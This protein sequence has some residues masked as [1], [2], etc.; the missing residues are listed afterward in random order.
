MYEEKHYIKN[1][2]NSHALVRNIPVYEVT[3]QSNGHG[4]FTADKTTGYMNDVIS[5][6]ATP[7]ADYSFDGYAIT[8]ATLTGNQ[9]AINGSDVT[10]QAIFTQAP[11]I[12]A[13]GK[14]FQFGFPWGGV[15]SDDYF[16]SN[17]ANVHELTDTYAVLK[18]K[19][20][21]QDLNPGTQYT[22]EL[23]AGIQIRNVNADAPFSWRLSG[24]HDTRSNKVLFAMHTN[25]KPSFSIATAYVETAQAGLVGNNTREYAVITKQAIATSE[26]QYKYICTTDGKNMS[27]YVDGKF[28]AAINNASYGRLTDQCHINVEGHWCAGHFDNI[29]YATVNTF[30]A[31]TAL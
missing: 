15:G 11:N 3:L 19:Y 8:G 22:P 21:M 5:M 18:F 4:T 20:I 1:R 29:T 12:I 27:A 13:S 25:T 9:F 30:A 14:Y 7:A 16:V 2:Y 31:A 10:A 28:Y 17:S 23:S 26:H 6:T 24:F